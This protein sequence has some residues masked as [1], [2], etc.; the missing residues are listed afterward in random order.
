MGTPWKGPAQ[1]RGLS[2]RDFARAAERLRCEP[3]A[4]RAVWE[5]EAAGRHFLPDASV[6]RRFEPHHFPRHLWAQLGFSVRTGEAPWRASLRQSSETLFQR[7]AQ[8]D[9]PAACHASSWGAPQIMGFNAAAAGFETAPAMVRH[10]ARGA[11]EQLGAFVQLIEGWGLDGALRAHDW[12]AFARRYNGTGQPEVYARRVEAA[13]RRHSGEPSPVVLR[14]GARGPSVAKLQRALGIEDDGAFGPQTLAA[15]ERFQAAQGLTVDG[16]VG[17]MTW[18]ALKA[19]V[20]AV[21]PEAAPEPEAQPTP[22]DAALDKVAAYAPAV[23]AVAVAYGLGALGLGGFDLSE[24][25][26]AEIVGGV[27]TALV[28]AAAWAVRKWRRVTGQ[29]WCTSTIGGRSG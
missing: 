4:I 12:L 17:A 19:Q 20:A 28:G 15:V 11:P 22:A 24:G 7:A 21:T 25:L 3:A 5:V 6:V 16:V 13:W 26:G 29:A 18:A 2:D 23:A 1:P 8:L 27:A 14:V 10:M 9:M